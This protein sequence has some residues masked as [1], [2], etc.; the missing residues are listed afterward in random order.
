[1][2][3]GKRPKYRTAMRRSTS[4]VKTIIQQEERLVEKFNAKYKALLKR[5]GLP[6]C[7][8]SPGRRFV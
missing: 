1:M 3:T 8:M 2:N 4:G 6:E 5:R 7:D